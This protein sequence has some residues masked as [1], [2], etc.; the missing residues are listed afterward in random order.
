MH[1]CCAFELFVFLG[2][3]APRL[4][5]ENA[6]TGGIT[7]IDRRATPIQRTALHD[8]LVARLRDMI[9][10]C[11]LVPG[12]RVPER[13]LCV[14]FA[15][16]RTPLREA[17]KV[18][19]SIG[20]L[21]LRLNR[22]AWVPPMGSAEVREV[23]D[24]LA[25]LER[26]AGELA[27]PLMNGRDLRD[28]Q[29]LHDT[30]VAEWRD[31]DLDRLFRTDLKFHRRLVEAARNPTLAA[32]HESLTPRVERA[33][34]IVGTT[35]ARMAV[36]MEEHKTILEAVLCR[37]PSRAASALFDHSIKTRDAVV[38]ALQTR[39]DQQPTGSAPAPVGR[40]LAQP[41]V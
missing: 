34:Y 40:M 13:E 35:E 37:D 25:G 19:A 41:A 4:K 29:R 9:L 23:F 31:G 11:D 22:G 20:L 7:R 10:R 8:E 2:T 32:L 39:L 38:T 1:N 3:R 36:A 28:V 21:E 17:L 12:T 15:I 16:S 33:R 18:L 6:V 14:R 30:L 26:R 24:V 27:A 5:G